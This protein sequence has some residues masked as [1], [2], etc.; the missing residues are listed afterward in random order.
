MPANSNRSVGPISSEPAFARR[1][2]DGK[3][4]LGVALDGGAGIASMSFDDE[5]ACRDLYVVLGCVDSA[6][7]KAALMPAECNVSRK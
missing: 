6:G 7:G 1:A 5:K 3:C 2:G 4:R